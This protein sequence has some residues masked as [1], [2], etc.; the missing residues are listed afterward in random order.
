MSFELYWKCIQQLHINLAIILFDIYENS[1]INKI[2]FNCYFTLL[3]W[4]LT[5]T[6][7]FETI[8]FFELSNSLNDFSEIQIEKCKRYP[9][10]SFDALTNWKNLQIF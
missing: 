4:I 3:I 10:K 9:F 2:C 1:D 5:Y 7:F 8:K 6:I